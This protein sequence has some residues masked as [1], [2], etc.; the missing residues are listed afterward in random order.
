MGTAVRCDVVDV[1]V[2]VV[3]CVV[4]GGLKGCLD[5]WGLL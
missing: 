5:T 4:D 2:V 1:V 3:V